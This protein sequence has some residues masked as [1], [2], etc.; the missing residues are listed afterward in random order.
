MKRVAVLLGGASSERA[1]SLVSGKMVL[2]RLP[3]DQ[4]RTTAYD[5]DKPGDLIR[6]IRDA[7]AKNIDVVF[8]ALHGTHGED[9]H[10]QGL[11]EILGLPYTGSGVLA[12]A[13]SFDKSAAKEA[14]RRARI[15]TPK[16][17]IVTKEAFQRE[18]ATVL[19]KIHD[20]LGHAIVVKPN[21]SGSSVGLSVR[22]ARKEW[23]RAIQ[24]ALKEDAD[25]C[26]VEMLIQGRELTIPVLEERGVPRA[27]SA[28]EIRTATGLFDY[29]AKYHDKRTQEICPAPISKLN[30]RRA[31]ALALKAHVA[32]GCRGYSRTD[33]ILDERGRLWVLETNTLP[34][35][36]PASLL[37]KSAKEEGMTYA[38]LLVRI[39]AEARS[40]YK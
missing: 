3:P 20:R 34:G 22:P 21:A 40:E 14:Y 16:G 24:N 13:V 33:M 35:L 37:P 10:I 6:L 26:L 8:N 23:K 7:K 28:I 27:M 39:L 17:V 11:L 19:K 5:P 2:S 4:F 15:P 18:A 9:G 12:S 36:T 31:N 25:A 32:L 29:K 1:V 38:D 30:T